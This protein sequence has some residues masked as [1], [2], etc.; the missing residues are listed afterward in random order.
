MPAIWSIRQPEWPSLSGSDM[1]P[2]RPEPTK[3]KVCPSAVSLFAR[4]D[5]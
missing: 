1:V 5:R 4:K 2:L 3:S